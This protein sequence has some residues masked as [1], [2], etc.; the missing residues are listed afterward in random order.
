MRKRA[1]STRN[2]RSRC[3]LRAGA[4]DTNTLVRMASGS[5]VVVLCLCEATPYHSKPTRRRQFIAT[6]TRFSRCVSASSALRSNF[7]R[8]FALC[9][10]HRSR[11]VL[12]LRAGSPP[13][14]RLQPRASCALQRHNPPRG[15]PRKSKVLD[16]NHAPAPDTFTCPHAASGSASHRLVA[17]LSFSAAALRVRTV[18]SASCL[19]LC[20]VVRIGDSS[21]QGQR[22]TVTLHNPSRS[23]RNLFE[24][25][26]RAL[27]HGVFRAKTTQSVVHASVS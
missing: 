20:K 9:A 6:H 13:K 23:S 21:R 1:A 15:G 3:S 5:A 4:G 10:K 11:D 26:R 25:H 17:S 12:S 19:T 14:S 8:V 24:Q 18:P 22:T 27:E 7:I 2:R 16:N